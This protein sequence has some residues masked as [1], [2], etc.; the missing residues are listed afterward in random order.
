M[1]NKNNAHFEELKR[2]R[3]EYTEKKRAHEEKKHEIIR[4]FGWE[5]DELKAWYKEHDKMAYPIESG[6][7]K[8]YRAFQ[9]SLVN[10][11]EEFEMEDFLWDREVEGFVDTLRKA[12]ISTFIYTNQSTAVMENL[13]GF[14]EAGCRMEG[15]VKIKRTTKRFGTETTEEILGIRF[16][17]PATTEENNTEEDNNTNNTVE[18][19]KVKMYAFTGMYIGE[20]DAKVCDDKILVYTKRKGEL[21]FDIK[22]GKEVDKKRYA[23]RIETV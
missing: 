13:H 22:T 9:Y 14:E 17:V 15:L 23:N 10:G 7:A 20:F 8:A 1:L 18:V 3:A 21:V 11:N 16:I 12:G 19:S 4:T 5:S 6:A 2:I